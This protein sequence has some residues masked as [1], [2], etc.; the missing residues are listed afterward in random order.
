M[1]ETSYQ[2]SPHSREQAGTVA[3]TP[4]HI[5]QNDGEVLVRKYVKQKDAESKDQAVRAFLPLVKHIAK[6]IALPESSGLHYEDIYQFGVLGLLDALERYDPDQNVLFKTFAYRRIQGEI[7]DAIRKSGALTR[8]QM[9]QTGRLRDAEEALRNELGR[10]PTHE[11]IQRE[12]GMNRK[13]YDQTRMLFQQHQTVSLDDQVYQD[14]EEPLIR[15]D[16]LTDKDQLTPDKELMESGLRQELKFLIKKLPER[17][18]LILALYY[19]EELT[20]AD[21]GRVINV[22]ESRVSQVIS[23]TLTEIRNQLVVIHR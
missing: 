5:K 1:E 13:E 21:I 6:R 19:Y 9:K 4:T 15:K 3:S 7:I 14:D 10:E 8:G 20:L 23:Q 16:L 11:E 12:A 2:S 17:N 18:R 22:T